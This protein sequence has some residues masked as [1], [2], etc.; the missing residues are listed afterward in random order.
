M[1]YQSYFTA[2][3]FSVWAGSWYSCEGFIYLDNELF[4]QGYPAPVIMSGSFDCL[5]S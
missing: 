2:A 4:I 1:T 5:V 3:L